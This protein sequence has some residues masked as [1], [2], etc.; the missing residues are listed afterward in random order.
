ML[1]KRIIP[2]LDIANNRVVKGVNF[3][4]LIDSGDPVELARA[5]EEMGADELVFLD[6]KASVDNKENT[7]RLAESV[8]KVLRI[9]FTI[10]GGIKDIEHVAKIFD[11][12]ADKISLNS[13]AVEN[14]AF[15]EEIANRFGSQAVVIAID[16][17]LHESDYFVYTH[18]ARKKTNLTVQ[19]WIKT[20]EDA[21]A[22]EL[23]ITSIDKDG[24]NSGFD[25]KLYKEIVSIIPIIAS[26]GAGSINDFSHLLKTTVV[27]A[28]LAAGIFHRKEVSI[29][30]LKQQ[31]ENES[32]LIRPIAN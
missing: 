1:T 21:G 13:Y 7:Y 24:T 23:L 17:K 10:G 19:S 26:G 27:S 15:I 25:I 11:S 2:C 6:I 28:A 4:N 16:S 9:P 22:G 12:G 31:L 20:V 5:Y 8:A 18:G 3:E 29:K 32:I 30:D 14:P